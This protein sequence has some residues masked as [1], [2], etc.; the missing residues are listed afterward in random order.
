MDKYIKQNV[1]TSSYSLTHGQNTHTYT[2]THLSPFSTYTV[3]KATRWTNLDAEAL[4]LK[5]WDKWKWETIKSKWSKCDTPFKHY[6]IHNKIGAFA[7]FIL[8]S[9]NGR[10]KKK[11]WTF[12]FAKHF[13][14]NTTSTSQNHFTNMKSNFVV[15]LL[16]IHNQPQPSHGIW[17]AM[18]WIVCTYKTMECNQ[19]SVI[20]D[21]CVV[22]L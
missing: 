19:F 7:S 22:K 20:N 8:C 5:W 9:I 14:A 1:W 11:E 13:K 4:C 6:P 3:S 16:Y 12:K 18:K 2:H 21:L 10:T 15:F 17:M